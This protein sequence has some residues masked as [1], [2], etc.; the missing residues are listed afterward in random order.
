MKMEEAR[1]LNLAELDKVTGGTGTGTVC[2]NHSWSCYG[3]T[4]HP[5]FGL[6]DIWRCTKCGAEEYRIGSNNITPAPR[7]EPLPNP[8]PKPIPIG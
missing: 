5:V 7:P 4:A 3:Q 2:A 6:C 1:E 8:D